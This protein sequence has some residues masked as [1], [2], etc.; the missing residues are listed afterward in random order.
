MRSKRPLRG[1]KALP[2]P[3]RSSPRGASPSPDGRGRHAGSRTLPDRRRAGQA[4][5]PPARRTP[6]SGAGEGRRRLISLEASTNV[7]GSPS[8][9]ARAG[10]QRRSFPRMDVGRFFEDQPPTPTAASDAPR[11]RRRCRGCLRADGQLSHVLLPACEV[12]AAAGAACSSSR[13]FEPVLA[14]Q[15]IADPVERCQRRDYGLDDTENSSPARV[16]TWCVRCNASGEPGVLVMP[17]TLLLWQLIQEANRLGA[18]S[19]LAYNHQQ[20]TRSSSP[21]RE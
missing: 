5:R 15:A 4:A 7:S 6:R 9:T 17:T 8:Q 11:P 1:R 12:P 21:R 13:G 20:Q 19:G 16:S 10:K 18:S 14:A 3:A 2:R